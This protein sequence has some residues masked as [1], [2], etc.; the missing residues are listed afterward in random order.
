[1]ETGRGGYE[2]GSPPLHGRRLLLGYLAVGAAVAAAIAISLAVGSGRHTAPEFAGT[3]SSDSR[4]LGTS[5]RFTIEQSG[6]Y[7][8]FTDGPSGSFELR[9]GILAGIVDCRGAGRAPI[10]LRSGSKGGH[11]RPTGT[12]GGTPVT[13]EWHSTEAATTIKRSAEDTVGRLL[14]AM[15]A[16]IV[17]ARFLGAAVARIDQPRVMGEVLAGI[18]LGPTLLGAVW[19]EAE[20][21]LF[22]SDI[23]PLLSAIAQVGLVFYLFLVGMEFD[24]TVLRGRVGQAAFI[25]NASV[26]LPLGLGFLAAIPLYEVLAPSDVRY[27]AF[28][29]FVGVAMAITAFPVLARILVERR[30]LRHPVGALSLASAAIDDVTA[31]ALL[32]LA[33]AVAGTGSGVSALEVIGWTVLFV[34]C[35]I[36]FVKPFLNRAAT[37]YAE[38]GHLPLV[39]TGTIFVGVLL[40]AFA[41]QRAGL[42]PIFGA[43]VMGSVMPR[44]AGLTTDVSRRI[45]DFVTIILLPLFFAVSGLRVDITG[46][47]S[48]YLWLVA[49]GLIAIAVIGK[50]GGGALAARYA[51]FGSRDA[52]AIG[53]LLNTRGLTELIVL[54]IALSAG[55]I[56]TKLFSMLVIMALVTTFMTGP[57]LR[58]I[59]PRRELS[60]PAEDELDEGEPTPEHA[61][62][63]S[64][65]VAPQDDRNLA[66]LVAIAEPLAHGEP[67]REL[68]IVEVL[69]PASLVAGRLRDLDDVTRA[70][71]RLE[72]QRRL[73]LR[74]GVAVRVAAF[75]SGDPARDY[76]RLA[77]GENVG[78]FLVDGRRPLLGGTVQRGPVA[79]VLDSAPCDVAVLVERREMP[80]IDEDHPVAVPFSGAEHDWAALEVG[81]RIAS[82]RGATLRLV[83]AAEA[84]GNGDAS[85][86]LAD[87]S[88]LV[89]RLTDVRIEPALVAP[90]GGGIVEATRGTG[91]L[92][93]GLGSDWRKQGLGP[94]RT[95]IAKTA[96]PPVLFVR[97]G[98][99]RGVL[100]PEDGA[101]TGA[102]WSTVGGGP[103][104]LA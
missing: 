32:A 89:Q 95:A 47:D 40:A 34:V 71:R 67:P 26:A 75:T 3:Y 7:V 103:S 70:N 99:R 29:L 72:V 60:S 31:W 57:A 66:A 101:T 53:A 91:L 79:R 14:L 35:M 38:V 42:A 78:L 11:P 44:N 15:A 76:L 12:V 73:L 27:L 77:S 41:S 88:M 58:L 43:F 84:S 92:V 82:A 21:Y 74:S 39:W 54:N 96:A 56:S 52:G 63:E 13:L 28:A 10:L 69:R 94:V 102:R 6:R 5:Q 55:A 33:L 23:T 98:E 48:G 100:R 50:F 83:G 49:L 104:A 93:V 4:C 80:V 68:V 61:R 51:G 65:V 85:G 46:L 22:P 18:L 90:G 1:M 86:I 97:R 16:I 19:P 45:D 59:D 87:A 24:P 17:F 81:I 2:G 20:H 37:A 36:A 25:S 30:M 9:R 62:L 8:A 64:I